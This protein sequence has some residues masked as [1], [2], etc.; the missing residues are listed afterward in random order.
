VRPSGIE[1]DC[2][3]SEQI[4]GPGQE[5]KWVVDPSL[6]LV[7]SGPGDYFISAIY[8]FDRPGSLGRL[9]TPK[10]VESNAIIVSVR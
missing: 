10:R 4:L 5:K 8:S 1:I 2:T 3:G 9:E 7:F 6:D